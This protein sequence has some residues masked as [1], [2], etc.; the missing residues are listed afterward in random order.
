MRA[1]QFWVAAAIIRV[2]VRQSLFRVLGPYG[3]LQR[4]L[5]THHGMGLP[6]VDLVAERLT[7]WGCRRRGGLHSRADFLKMMGRD[8]R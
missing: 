5:P 6:G 4:L 7:V 1:A 3:P 2:K 8:A